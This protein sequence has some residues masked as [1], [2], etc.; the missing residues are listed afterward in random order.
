[1]F[2]PPQFRADGTPTQPRGVVFPREDSSPE[3]IFPSIDCPPSIKIAACADVAASEKGIAH[4]ENKKKRAAKS[5]L[6]GDFGESLEHAAKREDNSSHDDKTVSLDSFW[7]AKAEG[8]NIDVSNGLP[9]VSILLP[10][11]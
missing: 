1:M 5:Q 4:W 2:I 6:V 11:L 3:L 10:F 8:M 7:K 9:P